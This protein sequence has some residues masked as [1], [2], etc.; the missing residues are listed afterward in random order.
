MK[1]TKIASGVYQFNYKGYLVQ[2]VKVE[3]FQNWYFTLNGGGADDWHSTKKDA[4]IAAIEYID[5]LKN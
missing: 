4:T 5:Y 2:L 3:G 1:T